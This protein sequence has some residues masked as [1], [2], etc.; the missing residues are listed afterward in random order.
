MGATMSASAE[1]SKLSY[2]NVSGSEEGILIEGPPFPLMDHVVSDAN[3][4]GITLRVRD[5]KDKFIYRARKLTIINNKQNGFTLYSEKRR[6]GT[7]LLEGLVSASNLLNGMILN[8]C[9]DVKIM[10][11]QFFSNNN[12]GVLIDL[13]SGSSFEISNSLISANGN[14]G[15]GI[16]PANRTR[17]K[18]TRTNFTAHYNGAAI[19]ATTQTRLDL[20]LDE[21]HFW[22]NNDGAVKLNE[23]SQSDLRIL[24]GNFTRNRGTT[25]SLTRLTSGS[26]VQITNNR[27]SYNQLLKTTI[28]S[29]V[30]EVGT[31]EDDK[32]NRLL[33]KDNTF[34]RNTMETI[35]RIGNADMRMAAIPS[36]SRVTFSS[37]ILLANLAVDVAFLS[38]SNANVTLNRFE[39]VQAQCELRTGMRFGNALISAANNFWGTNKEIEVSERICDS[40]WDESLMPAIITPILLNAPPSSTDELFQV[41]PTNFALSSLSQMLISMNETFYVEEGETSVFGEGTMLL[42]EPERGIVIS[43]TLHLSGTENNPI[44]IRSAGGGPWSGIVVKPS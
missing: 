3:S 37:N 29:S 4:R 23:I 22:S 15:L 40:R 35:V 24:R 13:E 16:R 18:I 36:M 25:F 43:G 32:R 12:D 19:L 31:L 28:S 2:V 26:N 7:I 21:C 41:A 1:Q 11:G 30:L 42:F 9:M 17:I 34:L 14:V 27:F 44:V 20:L 33:I 8:G 6:Q 38:V 10:S 5:S 39:N